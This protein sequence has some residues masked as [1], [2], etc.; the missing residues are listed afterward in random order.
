MPRIHGSTTARRLLATDAANR[1]SACRGCPTPHAELEASVACLARK[2]GIASMECASRA[3]KTEVS[4]AM[5]PSATVRT[6]EN[7]VH[8][9][10]RRARVAVILSRTSVLPVPLTLHAAPADLLVRGVTARKNVRPAGN[11]GPGREHLVRRPNAK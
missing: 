9:R 3:A 11:A 5:A 2:A 7:R 10:L 4:H 6:A 1:A 8:A